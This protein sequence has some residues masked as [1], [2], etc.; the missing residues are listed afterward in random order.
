MPTNISTRL[1]KHFVNIA[2]CFVSLAENFAGIEK[3][4][5]GFTQK[6]DETTK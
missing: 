5:F 2:E 4:F 6:E 3:C 1:T